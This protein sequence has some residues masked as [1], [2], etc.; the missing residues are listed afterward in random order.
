MG[1]VVYG[2]VRA[3]MVP[4][5]TMFVYNRPHAHYRRT[6][7]SS[8][9]TLCWAGHSCAIIQGMPGSQHLIRAPVVQC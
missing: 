3:V 8:L 5:S 1:S 9:P 6:R 4:E 7:A 2:A